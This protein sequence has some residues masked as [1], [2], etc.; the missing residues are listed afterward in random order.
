MPA[1]APSLGTALLA[2]I[3]LVLLLVELVMIPAQAA[4]WATWL[5]RSVGYEV[6]TMFLRL[7]IYKYLP[8]LSR[9]KL[10]RDMALIEQQYAAHP[11]HGPHHAADVVGK[12]GAML[13][14]DKAKLRR[15]MR[16]RVG[17]G[18][19]GCI[20]ERR[21][22]LFELAVVLAAAFHD[23]GH[24]GLNNGYLQN[25]QDPRFQAYEYTAERYSE[26]WFRHE[27]MQEQTFL[28]DLPAAERE[29]VVEVASYAVLK[30][31]MRMH[32]N[33]LA[34][35]DPVET[36]PLKRL[37]AL[38]LHAADLAN[39]ADA[40]SISKL[41]AQWCH[42]EF[43]SQGDASKQDHPEL[44][45]DTIFDREKANVPASQLY[46]VEQLV[47]PTFQA[48]EQCCPATAAL[49]LRGCRAN[50]AQCKAIIEQQA[51]Q[52]EAMPRLL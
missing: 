42:R 17:K 7:R 22:A 35:A 14:R 15:W 24:P 19:V 20:T 33:V 6:D 13:R 16:E 4:A 2:A 27:F 10:L 34:M 46:F 18:I 3:V 31:D 1:P 8:Q 49:G 28:N 26:Q 44:T 32:Q 47:A 50:A 48:L 36:D 21:Y 51:E 39:G 30:T 37:A 5:R 12:C 38:L 9:T 41:W 40:W 45:V 29:F 11:Y 52:Q 43:H 23:A 25:S